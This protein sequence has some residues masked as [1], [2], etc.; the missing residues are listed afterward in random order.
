MFF[1]KSFNQYLAEARATE[2]SIILDVRTDAEY[3]DFHLEDSMHIPLDQIEQAEQKIKDKAT[4]IFV[5]CLSGARSEQAK[6]IL[7]NL[8][9]KN[10][11]NIG[12]ILDYES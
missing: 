6:R 12:G 9:Y 1:K 7:Q 3:A 8:G 11:V 2:N 10:V 5:H 4:P